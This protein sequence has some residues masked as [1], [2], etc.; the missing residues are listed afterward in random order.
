MP[1]TLRTMRTMCVKFVRAQPRSDERACARTRLNV[2]RWTR[3]C[4]FVPTMKS[5]AFVL[6]FDSFHV[7]LGVVFRFLP[8]TFLQ[9]K[10][11]AS[12]RKESPEGGA[13]YSFFF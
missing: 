9:K 12:E 2:L 1:P 10:G 6:G 5:S 3:L 8:Q 4:V 13:S 7:R 11:S